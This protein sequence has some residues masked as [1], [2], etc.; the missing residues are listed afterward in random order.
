MYENDRASHH[1]RQNMSIQLGRVRQ[2]DCRE[3]K[4]HVAYHV[5]R[6]HVSVCHWLCCLTSLEYFGRPANI[7]PWQIVASRLLLLSYMYQ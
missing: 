6:L 2:Q 7:I 4:R 3:G 5:M 1:M